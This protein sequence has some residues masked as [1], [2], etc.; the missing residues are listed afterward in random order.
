MFQNDIFIHLKADIYVFRFIHITSVMEV[1]F[2]PVHFIVCLF[3]S[4]IQNNNSKTT[5]E[6]SIVMEIHREI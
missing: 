4:K 6:I 5:E 1:V 3:E 2:N